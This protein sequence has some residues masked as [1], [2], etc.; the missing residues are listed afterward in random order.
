MRSAVGV[1]IYVRTAV[2]VAVEV[3]FCRT[4]PGQRIKHSCMLST[5]VPMRWRIAGLILVCEAF[6]GGH[7]VSP[8]AHSYGQTCAK[9]ANVPKLLCF[10]KNVTPVTKLNQNGADAPRMYSSVIFSMLPFDLGDQKN[11]SI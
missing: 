8:R 9:S 10:R 2:I 1:A 6:C 4:M 7:L 3:R 5:K 11:W